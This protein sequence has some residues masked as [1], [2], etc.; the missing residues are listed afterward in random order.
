MKEE[1]KTHLMQTD[2]QPHVCLCFPD[3]NCF[4]TVSKCVGVGRREEKNNALLCSP[5]LK[6][7]CQC[8]A[9]LHL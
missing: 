5:A 3:L 6:S 9:A 4:N 1:T 2:K 7:I 8:P